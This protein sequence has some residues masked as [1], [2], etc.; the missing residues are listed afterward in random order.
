MA[1]ELEDMGNKAQSMTLPDK[2]LADVLDAKNADLLE[3]YRSLYDLLA[4]VKN[5][6]E[7]DETEKQEAGNDE[8]SSIIN[9]ILSACSSFDLAALEEQFALLKKLRLPE[10]LRQKMPAL[11]KAVEDIEFEQIE[12]LLKN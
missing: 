11:S 2:Q 4:P 3:R 9:A 8:I 7:I 10:A 6:G 12:Q 1:A 5:Y